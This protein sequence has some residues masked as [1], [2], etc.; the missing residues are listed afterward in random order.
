MFSNIGGSI[1]IL[2]KSVLWIGIIGSVIGGFV[3][4][5][6]YDE[7]GFD[8]ESS[9]I[10]G[11]VYLICGVLGSIAS[12]LILYGFG[13]LIEKTTEIAR[14]TSRASSTAKTVDNEKMK[15]LISWREQNLISAEEFE[16]KKQELLKG[17]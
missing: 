17:E 12:S 14:N 6:L 13:E 5:A 15:N 10:A 1:K 4:F 11:L 3:Y 7:L 8:G 9:V 2:A 16:K